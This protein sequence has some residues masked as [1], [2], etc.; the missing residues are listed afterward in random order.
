MRR[1]KHSEAFSLFSFQ[2]IIT[3]VTGIIILLTLFLALQLVQQKT[4]GKASD[5]TES[6]EDVKQSIRRVNEQIDQLTQTLQSGQ[7]FLAD[8]AGQSPASLMQEHEQLQR[9]ASRLNA[10]LDQLHSDIAT[11]QSQNRTLEQSTEDAANGG[12]LS[13][14]QDRVEELKKQ[15]KS[16]KAANRIVYNVS[17]DLTKTPWLVDVSQNSISVVRPGSKEIPKH[18]DLGTNGPG[19]E[20][21]LEWAKRQDAISDYFVLLVRP[22]SL[23]SYRQVYQ[24]LDDL[25]FAIGVD[26]LK[27]HDVLTDFV[28]VPPPA[29]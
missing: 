1:R 18:F 17:P 14:L 27:Q 8:F 6:N 21:L 5:H 22:K 23:A 4:F 26:L 24:G 29:Q 28:D 16:L 15:L 19:I 3:S 9:T 20:G 13:N 12:E 2:D 25:K 7:Q 11:L 10:E